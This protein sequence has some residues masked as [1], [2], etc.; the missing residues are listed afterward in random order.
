MAAR[1]GPA[2]LLGDRQRAGRVPRHLGGR[3]RAHA[4]V[5]YPDGSLDPR[6]NRYWNATDACCDFAKSGVD[7]VAYLTAVLKDAS[8]RYHVDPKRVF[9]VGHSNGAFMAHRMAC[10]RADLVVGVAALAGVIWNDQSRCVP[11]QAVAVAQIHG[12]ADTTIPYNGGQLPILNQPFPSAMTTFQFWSKAAACTG[13]MD[14]AALD[15]D[16][17]LPGAETLLTRATGCKAGGAAELWRLRGAEHLPALGTS[18]SAA[19]YAFFEAHPR[20]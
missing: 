11:S 6:G 1:R 16:I 20:P 17:V 2:R 10:E 8:L 12:D 5:V 9:I 4:V 15:L 13:Q 18:F 14:G 7:D 19:V 3:R